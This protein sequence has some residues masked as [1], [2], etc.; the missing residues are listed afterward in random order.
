METPVTNSKLALIEEAKLLNRLSYRALHSG[1]ADILLQTD[2]SM[3]QLRILFILASEHSIT[4][5]QIAEKLGVGIPTASYQVE[6]IVQADFA[7]RTEDSA[8]RRRTFVTLTEQG[9]ELVR[10]VSQGRDEQLHLVL[11]RLDHADLESFL[12]GL[13]AIARV[14]NT[15]SNPKAGY[16]E[17]AK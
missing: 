14:V 17:D 13:R 16:C 1:S 12:Q 2:L 6:K 15:P 9:E 10:Q 3:A 7:R 8:D 5:G 4:I 11:D